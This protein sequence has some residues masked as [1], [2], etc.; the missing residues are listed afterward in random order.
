MSLYGALVGVIAAAGILVAARGWVGVPDRPTTPI[1]DI[2][3][4]TVAKRVGPAL[5][6]GLVVWGVSGW[7]AAGLAIAAITLMV[8]LFF[9]AARRRR[10]LVERAD[11]LAAWADMLRDTIVAHAGLQQAIVSTAEVAPS[12]IRA[13][14]RTL[15]VRSGRMSLSDAL[16]RFAGEMADPVADKIVA[17]IVIADAHQAQNLPHLL[18]EIAETTRQQA[19]MRQRVETS[20]AKT[21][22]SSRAM[23]IITGAMVVVLAAGSP[24][25]M[26]PYDTGWGQ[27]VLA[28]AGAL[29]AGAVWGLIQ[30]SRPVP[31][32]RV[33]AGVEG[34]GR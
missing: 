22:A 30:L 10:E 16:R 1:P 14:V 29:F 21:Y 3:P 2:D 19:S 13:Q 26:A 5:L 20:R 6:A 11:A 9:D 32:P 33:L 24:A 7:P 25:F 4:A 17:A 12:A 15:A 18:G 23:V 34:R 8:P 28:L 27:L 31:E